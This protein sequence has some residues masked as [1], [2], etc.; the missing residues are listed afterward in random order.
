MKSNPASI[1]PITVLVCCFVFWVRFLFV[2]FGRSFEFIST[3]SQIQIIS[4]VPSFLILLY[5]IEERTDGLFFFRWS[6]ESP[7]GIKC[8]LYVY[9]EKDGYFQNSKNRSDSRK[10]GDGIKR[11]SCHR[12]SHDGLKFPSH[13]KSPEVRAVRPPVDSKIRRRSGRISKN[14]QT[15]RRKGE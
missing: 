4:I 11:G 13:C 5:D 2:L 3:L 12:C 15:Q 6:G 14:K 8:A 10:G 7:S 9:H 1:Y